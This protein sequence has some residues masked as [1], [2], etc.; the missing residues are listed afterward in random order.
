M[1]NHPDP[2]DLEET[3]R[4]DPA[5]QERV[6]RLTTRFHVADYIKLDDPELKALLTKVDS[7]R[8][9]PGAST[10]E[11]VVVNKH[12]EQF[13]ARYCVIDTVCRVVRSQLSQVT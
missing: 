4:I 3:K 13:H 8:R 12:D 10:V 6:A 1:F 11:S 7:R 9:S 5:L 2:Y